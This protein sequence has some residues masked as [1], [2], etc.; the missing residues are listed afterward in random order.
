MVRRL[1]EDIREIVG[2]FPKREVVQIDIDN[3]PED[4]PEL[5][6][7]N[8][9]DEYRTLRNERLKTETRQ[10]QAAASLLISGLQQRLL[11]SIEAFAR[12][13]R[14]HRRTVLRQWEAQHPAQDTSRTRLDLIG[15]SVASDLHASPF[16][17]AI[18]SSIDVKTSFST[19]D[20]L[21][22]QASCVPS[23]SPT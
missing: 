9:L 22:A 19:K 23:T 17:R 8:L 11:S 3:L 14:V 6:L 7:S 15:Q 12:T 2:G 5:Q 10:K 16:A 1:K 21:C 13:L 18:N 4:A 20:F